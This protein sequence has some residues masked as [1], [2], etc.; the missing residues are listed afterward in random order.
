MDKKVQEVL[1][2]LTKQGIEIPADVAKLATGKFEAYVLSDADSIIKDGQ[3]AVNEASHKEKMEDLK[4]YKASSK[5]FEAAFNETKA[6]LDSGDSHNAKLL[7]QYKKSN[8]RLEKIAGKFLSDAKVRWEDAAKIIPEELKKRF[9]FPEKDGEL[10]DQELFDNLDRFDEYKDVNPAAFGIAVDKDG[11]PALNIPKTNKDGKPVTQA[12]D[13]T[14]R[15]KS[16]VEKMA[17]GYK[18]QKEG[19]GRNPGTR[20]EEGD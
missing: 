5:K 16:P 2:F 12:K 11:K 4:S 10:D 3:I 1:D 8:E 19:S 9:K 17:M 18:D 7:E 20:K 15:G 6:A 13:E 14:W